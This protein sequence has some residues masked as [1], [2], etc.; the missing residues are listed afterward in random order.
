MEQ[1]FCPNCET[2]L[3]EDAKFCPTCG[4]DV[5]DYI[6]QI[7]IEREKQIK[8]DE[9]KEHTVRNTGDT[10]YSEDD[11]EK[12]KALLKR[13]LIAFCC[14][15]AASVIGIIALMSGGFI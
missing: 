14:T 1:I 11:S 12:K 6:R 3:T 4:E 2:E 15:L 8:T 10:Q 7:K 9:K 13:F 5:A